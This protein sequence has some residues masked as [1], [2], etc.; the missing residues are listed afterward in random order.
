MLATRRS[1]LL[2]AT[3]LAPGRAQAFSR[4]AEPEAKAPP[5]VDP[6]SNRDAWFVGEVPDEPF[7]VPTVDLALLPPEFR[8]PLA[9]YDGPERVRT[10]VID[11]H[12]RS[13]YRMREGR[14]VLRYGVGVGRLH[15]DG[16]GRDQAQ[17]EVAGLAHHGQDAEAAPEHSALGGTRRREPPRMPRSLTLP[18]RQEHVLPHPQHQRARRYPGSWAV[19]T[20]SVTRRLIRF[21]VERF[22]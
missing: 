15:M 13:L 17:G 19:R 18:K 20:R 1:L 2:A 10:L 16:H 21:P 3:L 12:E 8:N 7:D 22:G 6:A 9:N 14:P 5:P 4:D 11:T